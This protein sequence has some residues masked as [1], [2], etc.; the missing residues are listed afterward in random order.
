MFVYIYIIYHTYLYI[1][2]YEAGTF[3]Y[4]VTLS[5]VDNKATTSGVSHVIAK[6]AILHNATVEFGK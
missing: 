1:Y 3:M 2:I 5:F 6:E 4:N